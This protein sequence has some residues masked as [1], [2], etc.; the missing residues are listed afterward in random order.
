[1][2]T[3]A[4]N[5]ASCLNPQKVHLLHADVSY[6]VFSA[7]SQTPTQITKYCCYVAQPVTKCSLRGE[8]KAHKLFL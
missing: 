3:E 2:V 1:M 6:S 8:K 4:N 7:I 5:T